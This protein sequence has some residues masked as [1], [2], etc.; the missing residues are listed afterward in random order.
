MPLFREE[1]GQS[2]HA[3]NRP[4]VNQLVVHAWGCG[5]A[6]AKQ[7]WPCYMDVEP[8]MS[9]SCAVVSAASY[10]ML[11]S[12]V[13]SANISKLPQTSPHLSYTGIYG[14]SPAF[15]A[16]GSPSTLADQ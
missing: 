1:S 13:F 5:V 14:P 4:G 8:M 16:C 10:L 3:R 6:E 15:L 2:W 11:V 7:G 9:P 12:G